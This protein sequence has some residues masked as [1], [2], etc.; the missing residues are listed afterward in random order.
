LA[1]VR[2]VE[3][4]PV[5]SKIVTRAEDYPWSSARTHVYGDDDDLLAERFKE[6]ET[7]GVT[8]W[9]DFLAS[10]VDEKEE[11]AL[12][13]HLRTGRPI[14]NDAFIEELERLTGRV[15]KKRPPGRKNEKSG[16]ISLN[17]FGPAS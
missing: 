2:Y 3:N 7:F 4:N 16:D 10:E 11:K 9:A 14:G 15:L 6:I 12:A 13:K 5:R 8:N 1:A 17:S